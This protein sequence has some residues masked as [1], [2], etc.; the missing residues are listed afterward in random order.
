[1]FYFYVLSNDYLSNETSNKDSNETN[2]KCQ[3]I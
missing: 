3:I 1:M 2:N